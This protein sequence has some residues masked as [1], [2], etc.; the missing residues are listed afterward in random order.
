MAKNLTE[1]LARTLL[2][3]FSKRA[4][5]VILFVD[6]QLPSISISVII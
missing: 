2:S 3:R 6:G 4:I 5:V 1:G